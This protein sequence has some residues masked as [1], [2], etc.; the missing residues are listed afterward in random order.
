[1]ATQP[2]IDPWG[3]DHSEVESRQYD[4]SEFD[5]I[6][7]SVRL[8]RPASTTRRVRAIAIALVPWAI[9]G[10]LQLP[11]VNSTLESAASGFVESLERSTAEPPGSDAVAFADR[12]LLTDE[13]RSIFFAA[14]PIVRAA[15]Q[16][17]VDCQ[18][19]GLDDVGCYVDGKIV[20]FEIDDPRLDGTMEITA[21]H[22]LLHAV[23]AQLPA[24]ERLELEASIRS[25]FATIPGTDAT[26]ADYVDYYGADSVDTPELL[27]EMHSFV[28]T[29]VAVVDPILEAH[30][31]RFFRDRQVVV[32][33]DQLSRLTQLDARLEQIR[34]RVDEI[35]VALISVQDALDRG[36]RSSLVQSAAELDLL[37]VERESLLVEFDLGLTEYGELW[38][39]QDSS[40]VQNPPPAPVSSGATVEP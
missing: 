23:W 30:Y 2:P 11:V 19:F 17:E 28:G 6:T 37:L 24:A 10:A 13:G 40:T 3:N 7:G 18:T 5:R 34:Q 1:M 29:D 9:F 33:L 21:A 27:D 38:A 39:L 35:D 16:Y 12:L 32:G 31:A 8:R 15:P 20:I 14:R 26:I 25:A 22:E 36:S 4:S